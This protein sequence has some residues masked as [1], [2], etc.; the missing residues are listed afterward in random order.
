MKLT[1]ILLVLAAATSFMGCETDHYYSQFIDNQSSQ[2]IVF[3]FSGTN[4]GNFGDSIT[5]PPG[6]RMEIFQFR[7]WGASPEGLE[8][9]IPAD[10]VYAVVANGKELVKNVTAESEWSSE[11]TGKRTTIQECTFLIKEQDLQ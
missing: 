3:H 9:A 1:A 5:V 10:S 2:E 6:E 4:V 11:T 8:C 7:K